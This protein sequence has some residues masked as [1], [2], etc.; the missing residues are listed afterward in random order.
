MRS[1]IESISVSGF[2]GEIRNLDLQKHST[3]ILEDS[4]LPL[5]LNSLMKFKEMSLLLSFVIPLLPVRLRQSQKA[6]AVKLSAMNQHTY[7]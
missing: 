4:L 3:A 5:R 7:I 6:Q 2:L 1:T